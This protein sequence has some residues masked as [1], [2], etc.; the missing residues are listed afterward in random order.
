[1]CE[2]LEL[3]NCKHTLHQF[4]LR[5]CSP[6]CT[7]DYSAA[8]P[9]DIALSVRLIL[10]NPCRVTSFAFEKRLIIFLRNCSFSLLAVC[11]NLSLT[12]HIYVKRA[13]STNLYFSKPYSYA[14]TSGKKKGLCMSLLTETVLLLSPS[15][16]TPGIRGSV[17]AIVIVPRAPCDVASLCADVVAKRVGKCEK[18]QR[19]KLE[20]ELGKRSHLEINEEEQGGGGIEGGMA[21]ELDFK[22]CPLLLKGKPNCNCFFFHF[23]QL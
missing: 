9:A 19:K 7:L 2:D 13:L 11:D 14:G 21:L 6:L 23:T 15:T 20:V 12:N 10:R 4:V 5:G 17:D 8:L 1:M 16:S 18:K 3:W 22:R